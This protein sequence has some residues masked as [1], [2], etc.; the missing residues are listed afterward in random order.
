MLTTTL[1]QSMQSNRKPTDRCQLDAVPSQHLQLDLANLLRLSWAICSI[2]HPAGNGPVHSVKWL[3]PDYWLLPK[4]QAWHGPEVGAD[5][6]KTPKILGTRSY[7]RKVL[8]RH[9]QTKANSLWTFS[10]LVP[11]SRIHIQPPNDEWYPE[12]E[13]ERKLWVY[14]WWKT[15]NSDWTYE[16][17]IYT[18]LTKEGFPRANRRHWT[19]RK[20]C[21]GFCSSH[22]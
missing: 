19:K 16:V 14:F 9:D 10:W 6:L 1:C 7:A 12:V 15:Y 22:I 18:V 8:K 3:P 5:H 20:S 11:K 4:V 13:A 2:N 21:R 17:P